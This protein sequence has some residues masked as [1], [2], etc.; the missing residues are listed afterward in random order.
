MSSS[1]PQQ[2]PPPQPPT[3]PTSASPSKRWTGSIE[4]LLE[5]NRR[6]ASSCAASDPAFFTEMASGQ[7]PRYLWIGCSDSR[8]P[9]NQIMNL[10]PGAVFVQ[11]N[12]GNLATHK[13]L[14]AM[15]CLEYPVSVLK[16]E[17]VVVCGHHGCG[18]VAGALAL[19]HA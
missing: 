5:S 2:P 15:S 11:R 3:R 9:A 1:A 17:H 4:D 6:W 12:V 10:P 18:A 13:D 16:V 7:T 19:G 14:N 8:V